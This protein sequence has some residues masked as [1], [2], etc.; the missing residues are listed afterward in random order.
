MKENFKPLKDRLR[1]NPE[2]IRLKSAYDRVDINGF[3]T[4][5]KKMVGG[6]IWHKVKGWGDAPFDVLFNPDK[7]QW[8]KI[9]PPDAKAYEKNRKLLS[10]GAKMVRISLATSG[11]LN[12]AEKVEE[13]N[14]KIDGNSTV[15]FKTNHLGPTQDFIIRQLSKSKTGVDPETEKSLS[16]VSIEAF[17]LAAVLY[18]EH[19]IWTADP[20]LGNIVLNFDDLENVKVTLIDFEKPPQYRKVNRN[21]FSDLFK[22][23]K[24]EAEKSGISIS[25]DH[26]GILDV[27]TLFS[28]VKNGRQRVKE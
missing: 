8:L 13:C 15:G 11:L 1:V 10:E 20:N 4:I 26:E 7:Q 14:V 6:E 5:E 2:I 23:F 18:V 9:V 21:G 22:L 17:N 12:Y 3:R 28:K 24:N 25:S 27:D 19:G 16:S